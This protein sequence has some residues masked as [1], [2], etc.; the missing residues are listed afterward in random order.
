MNGSNVQSLGLDRRMIL[1]D[2]GFEPSLFSDADRPLPLFRD[3]VHLS[4]D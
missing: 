1:G 3:A 2:A 4:R